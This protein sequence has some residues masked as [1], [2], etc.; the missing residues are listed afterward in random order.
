[1]NQRIVQ[2]GTKLRSYPA[3]RSAVVGAKDALFQ[4]KIATRVLR[5]APFVIEDEFGIRLLIP[6]YMRPTARQLVHR[7]ADR[8]PFALMSTLLRPGDVVLDVGANVGVYAVHA[9]RH[10]GPDGRVYAFEPVPATA[11]RLA[12]TL[13]INGCRN[14]TVVRAAV[15]D[16]PGTIT[17]NVYSD[18]VHADWNSMG[19]HPMRSY[20]GKEVHPDLTAEARAET[21]DTWAAGAGIDD[22]AFCKV[23]VE[24]FERHVF[25]GA[26]R[27][28]A[29]RRIRVIAFEIS[30][31]PLAGEG[32]TP[33]DVFLALT[34]HG[35]KI[36]RSGE[37]GSPLVGPIDPH[38][39]EKRLMSKPTPRPF[40]ANYFAA[41]DPA[42]VMAA[43]DTVTLGR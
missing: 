19:K 11:G 42:A 24:G 25:A 23:D 29:E 38:E 10:V 32:G 37:V 8:A 3:L 30:E 14:V 31:D 5:S 39:E 13:A 6:P 18:P 12:E 15:T 26:A 4:A 33:S 2:A 40:V 1:M 27:L 7:H 41:L 22:V 43:L 28:L 17:M 35:Y 16:Q 9:S 34:G 20:A 21:L 36:L